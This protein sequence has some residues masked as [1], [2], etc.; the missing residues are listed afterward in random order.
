[1][2]FK[3]P[4]GAQTSLDFGISHLVRIVLVSCHPSLQHVGTSSQ[5][6]AKMEATRK[7]VPGYWGVMIVFICSPEV[8]WQ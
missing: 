6:C 4:I 7:G 1:M 8:C 3:T 2:E 5:A